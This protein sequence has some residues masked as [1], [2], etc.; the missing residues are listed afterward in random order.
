MR[1]FLAVLLVV[2]MCS[3]AFAIPLTD[4]VDE[5][6]DQISYGLVGATVAGIALRH[7]V[8]PGGAVIMAVFAGCLN[9]VLDQAYDRPVKESN[10]LASGIGGFLMTII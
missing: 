4:Y 3:G 8:V 2:V 6:R 7:A 10:I 1:K 5:N 9:T